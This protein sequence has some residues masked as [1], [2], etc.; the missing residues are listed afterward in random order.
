[1]GK[2]GKRFSLAVLADEPVVVALSLFIASEEKAGCF[3]ESPFEMGIADLTVFGAKLLTAGFSGAFDQAAIGDEVLD[4]VKAVDVLNLIQDDQAEDFPDSGEAPEQIEAS[5]VMPLG[6]FDDIEFQIIDQPV[7][8]FH[9]L[10]IHLDAFL[11]GRI[12]KVIGDSHPIRLDGQL[13]FKFGKI[14]LTVGVLDMG[15]K[16]GSFVHEVVSPS[17]KVA[18]G[19][20]GFRISIGCRQSSTPKQNGDLSGVDF[21]IF[22]L[23]AMDGFHVKCMPKHKR[24]GFPG[25]KIGQPVPD[26]QAFDGDNDI[27]SIGLDSPEKGLRIRSSIFVKHRVSFLIQ[28]TY[29]HGTGV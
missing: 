6:L 11:D 2:D 10:E 1:M 22:A 19:A 24:D 5:D 14:V 26:E 9:E 4:P 23:A 17:K 15:Q 29:V 21:V 12:G 25:T 13:L 16:F 28:D 3:G 27:L 18:G 7:I 8:K 20:H